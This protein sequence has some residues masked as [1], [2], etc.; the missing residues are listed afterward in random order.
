MHL[1][2]AQIWGFGILAGIGI[3][4]IG[5]L[6][7]IILLVAKKCCHDSNFVMIIKFFFSLAFGALIGDSIVHIL[8]EA[9]QS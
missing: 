1:T 2:V 5:F 9:Y 8:S 3:S 4:L 6:A 7:A